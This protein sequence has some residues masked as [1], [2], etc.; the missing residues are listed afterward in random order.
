MVDDVASSKKKSHH[1]YSSSSSD[2]AEI[3]HPAEW[4][5]ATAALPSKKG[6]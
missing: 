5:G 1:K 2:A 4:P 6:E 3:A